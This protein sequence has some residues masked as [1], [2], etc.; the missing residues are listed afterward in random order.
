MKTLHGL[1]SAFVVTTLLLAPGWAQTTLPNAP[2]ELHMIKKGV[3]M[4]KVGQSVD[5][6]DRGILLHLREV[7]AQDGNVTEVTFS[8]NG[9]GSRY[10]VGRRRNLKEES[11][12]RDFV[13]DLRTCVVDLVSAVAPTGGQPSATFR[14]LCE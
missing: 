3:V 14:L 7:R 9:E 13:K 1:G 11:A 4:L 8:I 10:N 5:L 2:G 6:T 12:T